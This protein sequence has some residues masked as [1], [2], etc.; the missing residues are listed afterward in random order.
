MWRQAVQF[1][2]SRPTPCLTP[3]CAAPCLSAL[4][5][6]VWHG[7]CSTPPPRSVPRFSRPGNGAG[8][9]CCVRV[10]FCARG[11]AMT[12]AEAFHGLDIKTSVS[13]RPPMSYRPL[14]HSLR[15]NGC[16]E[17]MT[18][19]QPRGR[20]EPRRIPKRTRLFLAPSPPLPSS[21]LCVCVCAVFARACMTVCVCVCS[22]GG[23]YG[24]RETDSVP[25][26][27]P[28]P[29][30]LHLSLPSGLLETPTPA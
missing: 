10:T 29:R 6:H 25:S 18:A 30:C 21:S 1:Q 5:V 16:R 17:W 26:S 12:D 13:A 27:P 2:D 9:G 4:D 22:D 14:A 20:Y 11:A 19:F 15:P 3:A 8:A 28:L 7:L 24:K 23:W